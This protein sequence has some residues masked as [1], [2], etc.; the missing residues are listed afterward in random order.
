MYIETFMNANYNVRNTRPNKL[1]FTALTWLL[2][3]ENVAIEKSRPN[4][5]Y[6]AVD[7]G[8]ICGLHGVQMLAN[9]CDLKY[10]TLLTPG[11]DT[12]PQT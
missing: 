4:K 6:P 10:L 11:V 12:L 8:I 3:T 9:A 7:V 1:S 2:V 5:P